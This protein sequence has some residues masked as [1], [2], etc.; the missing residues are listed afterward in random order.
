MISDI[1]I[2][3]LQ[4]GLRRRT[5][6]PVTVRRAKHG[7]DFDVVCAENVDRQISRTVLDGLDM[8]E[9]VLDW[10]DRNTDNAIE[11]ITAWKRAA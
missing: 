4:I 11:Y 9:H 1:Q 6:Q 10:E 5:E 3:V 8:Y 7:G 2:A